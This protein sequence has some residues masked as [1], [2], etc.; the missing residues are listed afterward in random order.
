MS[1]KDY[2]FTTTSAFILLI[3]F[4]LFISGF[5]I[6]YIQTRLKEQNHKL[7]SMFSLVSTMA[8][9]LNTINHIPGDSCLKSDPLICVSDDESSFTDDNADNNSES[10]SSSSGS[11]SDYESDTDDDNDDEVVKEGGNSYNKIITIPEFEQLYDNVEVSCDID[12]D[13]DTSSENDNLEVNDIN[14]IDENNDINEIDTNTA[15]ENLTDT[16]DE[17][18]KHVI[19]DDIPSSSNLEEDTRTIDYKK[20]TITKLKSIAQG[21][22]LINDSSKLKKNELLKLLSQE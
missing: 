4:I 17:N 9:Q 21:K 10:S 19:I 7:D 20:M 15:W 2:L 16:N 13:S 22:G 18:I 3:V 8:Q 14:D 6:Y 1:I 12:D 11:E 5:I